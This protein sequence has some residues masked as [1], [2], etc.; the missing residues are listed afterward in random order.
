MKA[1]PL[2]VLPLCVQV[3]GAA[4]A[5]LFAALA[6]GIAMSYKEKDVGWPIQKGENQVLA[7]VYFLATVDIAVFVAWGIVGP[8]LEK[9]LFS[10]PTVP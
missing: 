3:V 10:L 7:M 6:A 4:I 8:V 9:A 5:A 1:A 2:S